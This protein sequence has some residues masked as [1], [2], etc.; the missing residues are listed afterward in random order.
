M[1]VPKTGTRLVEAVPLKDADLVIRVIHGER[2]AYAG[3]VRRHQRTLYVYMR[4]MGL[5]HDTSLDLVQDAFVKAY[6]RLDECRDPAHF[7]AWLFSIARNL[8][9]DHLK[10]VRRLSVPFSMFPG[11]ECIPSPESGQSELKRTLDEA[12]DMLSPDLRDAFLLKH[13]AGYT[14]EEVAEIAAAS[15]S[16]VKMRVHRARETLRAFLTERGVHPAE[17]TMEG[18]PIVLATEKRE[19]DRAE[20]RDSDRLEGTKEEA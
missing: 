5:D 16:A 4:G 20:R 2:N 18:A 1:S 13:Q 14:Y 11:S 6:I 7:R 8:C 17:V 10:N 19:N 12:L 9:L 15:A 3:L